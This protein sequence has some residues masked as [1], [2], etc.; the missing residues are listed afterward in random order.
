MNRFD[1]P[2]LRWRSRLPW[3]GDVTDPR[4][5]RR[6]F[7]QAHGERCAICRA[8]GPL[9]EDHDHTTGLVRGLLCHS[10]NVMADDPNH[11]PLA[12]F[13]PNR[14]MLALYAQWPPAAVMGYREM[15]WP[16]G[17]QPYETAGRL[18]LFRWGADGI[19]VHPDHPSQW[20][21]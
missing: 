2:Y 19:A 20:P 11:R 17:V 4:E 14:R 21:R 16:Q 8:G 9:V 10:C 5:A 3:I 1:L 7:V 15:Y 12:S 18:S 6:A 13:L